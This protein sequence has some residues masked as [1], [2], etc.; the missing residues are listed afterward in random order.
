M[1]RMMVP[2]DLAAALLSANRP[3]AWPEGAR[4]RKAESEDGDVVPTGSLG[5]VRGSTAPAPDSAEVP[6]RMRGHHAYAVEWD[7][8][9]STFVVAWKLERVDD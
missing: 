9:V 1:K 4:V 7:L 2:P 3:G 8:G 5:T 6:P